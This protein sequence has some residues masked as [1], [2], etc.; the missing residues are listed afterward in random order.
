MMSVERQEREK[1]KHW[2]HS[3]ECSEH[4]EKVMPERSQISNRKIAC[5]NTSLYMP[6]PEH[7]SSL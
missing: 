7:D 4:G 6:V 1:N 2:E 3:H 5:N